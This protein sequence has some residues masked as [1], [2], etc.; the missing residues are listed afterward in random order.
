MQPPNHLLKSCL[1]GAT[2]AILAI[3][4]C[5]AEPNDDELRDGELMFDLSEDDLIQF[6]DTY[7]PD[8]DLELTR[9]RMTA[10][11]D[12][13]VFGDFC[14]QVGREAAIEITARQVDLSLEGAPVE[15][16]N[17][18]TAAW[19]AE[20][21]AAYEPPDEDDGDGFRTNGPW[22]TRTKGDFRLR[23]R[24]G[25]TTP[26]AGDRE[27]W[28]QSKF[29]NKDWAGV[30]WQVD[31]DS[32]CVN[33]GTNTQTLETSEPGGGLLET[34]NPSKG[35]ISNSGYAQQTTLHARNTGF[36]FGPQLWAVYTVLADG[37]GS[38]DNNG[39]HFGIC[40]GSLAQLF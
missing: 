8:E 3:T 19:I 13:A 11:F 7:V 16:M 18:R 36:D 5:D 32:L 30:W 22:S 35:C 15:E 31:A 1:R 6:H 25:V 17:S 27:A 24:N 33:T 28:T 39:V 12:C 4:A 9:A 37:C 29:Q 26:A 34:A 23:V 21:M 2:L 38:A 20:A 40:A 10:P 14:A